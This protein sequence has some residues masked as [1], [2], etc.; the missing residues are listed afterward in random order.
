MLTTEEVD[1]E[2]K[3]ESVPADR[4]PK[5]GRILTYEMIFPERKGYEKFG[6]LTFA[7]QEAKT[8]IRHY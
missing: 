7:E 2:C 1:A 3:I 8:G 4:C 6:G 5:T